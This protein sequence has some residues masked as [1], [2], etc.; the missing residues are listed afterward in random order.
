M[1][2]SACNNPMI[3]KKKRP[4]TTF[5]GTMLSLYTDKVEG[6]PKDE[7]EDLCG[8][9]IGAIKNY[10]IDQNEQIAHK[11]FGKSKN[12]SDCFK[13]FMPVRDS[14]I[15]F[16]E[17]CEDLRLDVEFSYCERNYHGGDKY[18]GD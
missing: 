11:G 10:N 16:N 18:T 14:D 4:V 15:D 7:Y 3:P 13:W 12:T 9:C 6:F 1:R 2:C 8:A 5:A 17:E